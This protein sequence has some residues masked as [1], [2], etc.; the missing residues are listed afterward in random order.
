[1]KAL[2]GGL[3]VVLILL[4]FDSSMMLRAQTIHK[5]RIDSGWQK[6]EVRVGVWYTSDYLFMGRGD[7]S[8]AP[9]LSPYAGYYHKSGLFLSTSLSY[10]AGEGQGRI[11][12]YKLSGG[13][14]YYGEKFEAGMIVSEYFF[15][16]YSYT[17]V[18]EMS[19][20]LSA[21]VGYD[22]A[23]FMVYADGALG[24]SGYT[25]VFVGAEI[26]RKFYAL[27]R[28]LRITPAVY[29]NAGTQQYYSQYYTMRNTQTGMGSGNGGGSGSGQ[30]PGIP[31][32]SRTIES[33]KFQLLDFETDIQVSYKIK[34]F[35]FYLASTF[36]FPV[37]PATIVTDQGTYEEDLNTGFYWSTGVR[38]TL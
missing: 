9:Y 28:K 5:F 12:L 25:D 3:F 24:W 2:S 32:S 21:Y 8:K 14:D 27:K 17:V 16:D 19:T 31:N 35:R 10:L 22:L 23:G 15:N 13:Y 30:Q 26:N 20:S 38:L 29:L 11:D 7:S 36:T 6:T 34:K 18:S 33:Q 37:N 4:M 1:M